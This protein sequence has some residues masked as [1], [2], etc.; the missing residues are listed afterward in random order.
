MFKSLSLPFFLLSLAGLT[1]CS[2]PSSINDKEISL[3]SDRASIDSIRKQTPE[4]VKQENDFLALVL[5]DMAVVDKKPQEV[6][7][8][9]YREVRKTRDSF[10][11]DHRKQRD[12]FNRNEKSTREKFL[13]SLKEE[14]KDFA[15]KKPSRDESSAFFQEQN[16][17]R[18][19]YFQDQSDKRKDFESKM[20]ESRKDFNDDLALKQKQFDDMYREYL[21]KFR[22]NQSQT[23][24]QKKAQA[25]EASKPT[26][27][28]YPGQAQDL[29]DFNKLKPTKRI[30]LG[31][32]EN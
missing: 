22:E 20:N 19:N 25:I 30:T 3:K 12:E 10:N 9:F 31:T 28:S 8:R 6:R 29:D 16:L 15:A 17:K 5:K 23:K 26:S 27:V 2:T 11:R 24:A 1:S 4:V 7:D 14:R 13:K 21:I 32:E 18:S